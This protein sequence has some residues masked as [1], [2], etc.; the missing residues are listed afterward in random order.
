VSERIGWVGGD[1][2]R[3]LYYINEIAKE[4]PVMG[5]IMQTR[6]NAVPTIEAS[7]DAKDKSNWTR[8]FWD[9]LQAE[10]KYFGKQEDPKFPLLKVNKEEL[11]SLNSV[12]FMENIMP[13]IVLVFGSGMIREPLMSALPKDLFIC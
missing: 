8:H 4:F 5:G 13:D 9:R 12:D 10:E 3:H 6:G 11:N 1:Q 7:A 2:P